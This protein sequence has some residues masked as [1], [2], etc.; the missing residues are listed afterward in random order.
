MPTIQD[1]LGDKGNDVVTIG[2]GETVQRA[3]EVLN[4]RRIGALVVRDGAGA[5]IGILTERDIMRGLQAQGGRIDSLAVSDLMSKD[6]VC[7]LPEDDLDYVMSRMTENRFRH[8]PIT[9]GDRLVGIISIGDVIKA[10]KSAR[11]YENRLLKDYIGG[12]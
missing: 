5:V 8:L 11:E 4:E 1:V 7:G 12:Y 2:P 3:V 6:L 10:L 9:S